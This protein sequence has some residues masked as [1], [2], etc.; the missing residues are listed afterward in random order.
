MAHPT[1][2]RSPRGSAD[3]LARALVH[4]RQALHKALRHL[5]ARAQ[6]HA[7]QQQAVPARH[8]GH[9]C[10]RICLLVCTLLACLGCMRI[11]WSLDD[12]KQQGPCTLALLVAMS[13]LC[14]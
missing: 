13:M 3:M 11:Q 5:A 6:G 4:H 2:S 1:P 8:K 12:N 7:V 10:F 14:K 9:A